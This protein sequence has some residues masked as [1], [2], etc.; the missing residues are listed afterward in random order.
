MVNAASYF[1]ENFTINNCSNVYERP[2]PE[3]FWKIQKIPWKALYVE[4]YKS[5]SLTEKVTLQRSLS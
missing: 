5:A 4:L 1:C 3:L 2:Y